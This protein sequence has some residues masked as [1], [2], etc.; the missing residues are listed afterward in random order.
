MARLESF[1]YKEIDGWGEVCADS[2]LERHGNELKLLWVYRNGITREL[3]LTG[4]EEEFIEELLKC[5]I[6][7][8]DGK[9]YDYITE[10][11]GS[12]FLDIVIDNKNI[13]CSG[14]GGYPVKFLDFCKLVMRHPNLSKKEEAYYNSDIKGTQIKP[15]LFSLYGWCEGYCD[16]DLEDIL[17]Y[18]YDKDRK[19]E[20]EKMKEEPVY[21][22]RAL[23]R[24]NMPYMYDEIIHLDLPKKELAI[25]I[26]DHGMAPEA[27]I[28]SGKNGFKPV[29]CQRDNSCEKVIYSK[30]IKLSDDDIEALLP[31]CDMSEFEKY[32]YE[33]I[34]KDT[35]GYYDEGS[36][37]EFKAY[38]DSAYPYIKWS[39]IRY[40]HSEDKK[41]PH[42]KL[43]EY[44]RKNLIGKDR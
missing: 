34:D 19:C 27:I 12:W 15:L 33:D 25:E 4:K 41:W 37:K 8:W 21:L 11:C 26:L 17:D 2:I 20:M 38:S 16:V 10:D 7:S 6:L 14:N 42:E 36:W 18:E 39:N 32:R 13:H 23:L 22:T 24:F 3:V 40:T 44:I 30:G 43:E 29:R 28:R 35:I 31:Y 9:S 1:H 5:D